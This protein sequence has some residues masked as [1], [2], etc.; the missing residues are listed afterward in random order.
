MTIFFMEFVHISLSNY[1]IFPQFTVFYAVCTIC[2][3]I[4]HSVGLALR[5][6]IIP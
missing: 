3:V 4:I 5:K 1:A 6:V 2:S